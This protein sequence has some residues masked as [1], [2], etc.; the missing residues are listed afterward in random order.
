MHGLFTCHI[1]S[2]SLVFPG[3][4]IWPLPTR[5]ESPLMTTEGREREWTVGF[6]S[7][8]NGSKPFLPGDASSV[9]KSDI[10]CLV[11]WQKQRCAFHK[12]RIFWSVS[13]HPS[14]SVH[15]YPVKMLNDFVGMGESVD[16]CAS[17]FL[18][19]QLAVWVGSPMLASQKVS[20]WEWGG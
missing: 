11:Y 18:W 17:P 9:L 5:Q 19:K 7:V 13:L 16:T 12:E 14:G 15:S 20:H 3:V 2:T 6:C 1:L 8:H 10:T 4:S